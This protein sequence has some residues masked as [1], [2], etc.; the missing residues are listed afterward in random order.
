MLK[1]VLLAPLVPVPSTAL[2][3]A[4]CG[5]SVLLE[6]AFVLATKADSLTWASPAVDAE[7]LA[8][9]AA[10]AGVS[11][12]VAMGTSRSTAAN[13]GTTKLTNRYTRRA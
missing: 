11:A 9:C 7:Q 5:E 4:C 3:M 1:R 12:C 13:A 6:R 2:E 8:V 10:A